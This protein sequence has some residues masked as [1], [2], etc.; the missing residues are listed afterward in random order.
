M[1]FSLAVDKIIETNSRPFTKLCA[2]ALQKW[3][4]GN[5]GEL[6]SEGGSLGSSADPRRQNNSKSI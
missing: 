4:L 6:A 1:T 5:E 3:M 2:S